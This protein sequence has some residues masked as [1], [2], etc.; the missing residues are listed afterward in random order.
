MLFTVEKLRKYEKIIA[1]GWN[2]ERQAW[3]SSLAASWSAGQLGFFR[4][5]REEQFEGKVLVG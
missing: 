2:A 4:W 3:V 1:T 5:G